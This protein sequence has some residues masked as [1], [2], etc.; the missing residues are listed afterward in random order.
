[1]EYKQCIVIR[2]DLGLSSGK[3]AA[4]AAHAS[5]MAYERAK[6]DERVKWKRS[7]QKKIV[8]KVG[9]V[10]EILKLGEE[11]ISAG[12]ACAVVKDA[13]LTEVPPATIT[14]IGIGP[15]RADD[16]DRITGKLKLL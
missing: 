16:L 11:A 7:G 6:E 5:I 10:D 2:S 8:L 13:G 3:I 1:M 12:V 4:Q 15:T 14:A 9:S